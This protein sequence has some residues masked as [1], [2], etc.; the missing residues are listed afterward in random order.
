[1]ITNHKVLQPQTSDIL[2]DINVSG[3]TV[4]S[5]GT[6]GAVDQLAHEISGSLKER[7]T[8]VVWLLDASLSQRKRR[9]EVA[10][11]IENVYKQLR[12]L[13]S[14]PDRALISGVVSYGN[15]TKFLTP[16]P[17]ADLKTISKAIRAVKND[18]S[19]KEFVFNA[20]NLITKNETKYRTKEKRNVMLIIVTD[21][22]G[23]DY[24]YLE[25][26]I[27]K[28]KRMGM[29]CYCVGNA[30]IFGR[31]KGYVSWEFPDGSKEDLP[32]DQGP[33][34]V[35]AERVILPFWGSA[36]RGLNKLSSGYGPYALTRLCAET[37]GIYFIA[38]QEELRLI[39]ISCETTF[40][41]IVLSNLR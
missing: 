35:K 6:A 31:E 25:P 2:K 18:T 22:R 7:K 34:T 21:E 5:G 38:D 30:S 12:L 11:R 39:L 29:K 41:I 23:D 15:E 19:G 10:K 9:E 17:I 36:G 32:V 20:I 40:P 16:E 13:D 27:A 14:D 1:M 8:L 28:L 3:T 4:T 24:L 37:G 26:T 33:E